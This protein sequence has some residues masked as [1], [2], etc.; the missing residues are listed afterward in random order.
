MRTTNNY[1]FNIL[2]IS[3]ST[4]KFSFMRHIFVLLHRT[5]EK[6]SDKDRF[7]FIN[8]CMPF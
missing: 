7:P 3:L 6:Y 2:I 5:P 4:L 1:V 8:T